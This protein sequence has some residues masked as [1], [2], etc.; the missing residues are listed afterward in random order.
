MKELYLSESKSASI[1]D[2][3]RAKDGNIE[4]TG[5]LSGIAES[6]GKVMVVLFYGS[7]GEGKTLEMIPCTAIDDQGQWRCVIGDAGQRSHI[8][9]GVMPANYQISQIRE[10]SNTTDDLATPALAYAEFIIEEDEFYRVIRFGGY[11]WRVKECTEKCGPGPNIFSAQPENVSLAKNGNL[12]MRIRKSGTAW[13]CSEVVLMENLGYG[14]YQFH[15]GPVTYLDINAVL[16]LFTWDDDRAQNHREIDIELAQWG[17]AAAKNAQYVV[18]PFRT[19]ENMYRFDTDLTRPA[20]YTF[21][22]QPD[23]IT[24]FTE[25]GDGKQTNR[26]NYTG[27]DIP[28]PGNENARINL[29]LYQGHSP[30]R[31]TEVIISDFKFRPLKSN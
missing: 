27:P 31:E 29:W 14:E 15:I 10:V 5:K 25:T 28:E 2:I 13:A 1:I 9:V 6:Q 3:S 24:C 11:L 17:D 22:W 4:I 30:A 7:G 12:H 23:S 18:Q 8:G 19:A 16:G 20:V 21:V 26:W